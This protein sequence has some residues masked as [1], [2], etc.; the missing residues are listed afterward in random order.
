MRRTVEYITNMK[1]TTSKME[2]AAV[3]AKKGLLRKLGGRVRGL[4]KTEKKACRSDRT[5]CQVQGRWISKS[6]REPRSCSLLAGQTSSL[7]EQHVVRDETNVIS[8]GSLEPQARAPTTAALIGLLAQAARVLAEGLHD[9]KHQAKG[10]N[11]TCQ[12][13]SLAS[14][15]AWVDQLK[16]E[17][18]A[19]D[20]A[21]W[22]ALTNWMKRWWQDEATKAAGYQEEALDRKADTLKY[23]TE[24]AKQQAE[25]AEMKL[26]ISITKAENHN[27]VSDLE[28]KRDDLQRQF[29]DLQLHIEALEAEWIELKDELER[30][31]GVEKDQRAKNFRDATKAKGESKALRKE[32]VAL[33]E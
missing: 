20:E 15:Q 25:I 31:L 9:A 29:D 33:K 10:N 11:N 18:G 21:D 1:L 19:A 16:T 6:F 13:V 23:Q 30:K 28:D 7:A 5:A 27:E 12:R 8:Y 17:A 4:F 32:L 24:V 14:T 3:V 22:M 2:P 26:A